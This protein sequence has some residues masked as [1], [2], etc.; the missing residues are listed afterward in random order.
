MQF[1]INRIERGF[2][3]PKL[4]LVRFI[5]VLFDAVAGGEL[6]LCIARVVD[7]DFSRG[8]S[9]YWACNSLNPSS[10]LKW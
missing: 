7:V 4:V 5:F 2:R 3:H 10:L 9:Y 1:C 8:Y 6:D